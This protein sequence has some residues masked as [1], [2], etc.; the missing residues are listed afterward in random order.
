MCIK[1]ICSDL[2]GT[3]LPYGE[4]SVSKEAI[5][6]IKALQNKGILFCPASGR[7]YTSL[8]KLFAPVADKCVFLCENG[9]VIY[10]DDEVLA[11]VVM[12][13]DVAFCIA[14][15][16]LDRSDDKGEVML[17]GANTS[18]LIEK[19]LGVLNRISEIGNN[20]VVIKDL[21]EIKEDIVKVSVYLPDGAT[22][23]ADRFIDKWQ[24]YNAAIAGPYWI[25]TTLANKGIG[26]KKICELLDISLDDVMAFG[27]NF[28][29]VSML[30]EVGMPY[31][32]EG[33][34]EKL[35]MRYPNKAKRPEDILKT[36]I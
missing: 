11:K 30:D 21:D 29:D 14:N 15:D 9:G 27:D 17:S 8:K 13:K 7:Q 36:L 33:A 16:F 10:K 1:M 6:L 12:P 26:V 28:N 18:Y 23:Y 31:I 35:R 22:K 5:S 2:D 3:L 34:D 4:D 19:G 20:L 32:M 25:D 24:D